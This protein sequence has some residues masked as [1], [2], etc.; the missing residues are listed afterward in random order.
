MMLLTT[1][2][3]LLQYSSLVDAIR[4]CFCRPCSFP[5]CQ[6]LLLPSLSFSF[7]HLDAVHIFL[8]SFLPSFHLAWISWYLLGHLSRSMMLLCLPIFLTRCIPSSKFALNL[9]TFSIPFPVW[10]MSSPGS[11]YRPIVQQSDIIKL[12]LKTVKRISSPRSRISRSS[13]T[14]IWR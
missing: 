14:G 10:N 1:I 3:S 12:S 13:P 6:T 5:W 8:L 9:S 2:T 7:S 11:L 4:I